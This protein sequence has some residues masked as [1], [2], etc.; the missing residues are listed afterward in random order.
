MSKWKR[1]LATV[2][3][4]AVL[5]SSCVSHSHTVG[6]GATG[7]AE[8]SVRQYYLLFG[9]VSLNS[10]DTQRMAPDLTS[11]SIETSFGIVDLLWAPFL[12]VLTMTTRTVVVRT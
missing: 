12:A 9:L 4:A 3:L 2:A 7:T 11:Y 8:S 6:L 10:V 5:A 1:P